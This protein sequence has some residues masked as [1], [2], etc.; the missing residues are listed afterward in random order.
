MTTTL[1][2]AQLAE[3]RAELERELGRLR[4]TLVSTE[5]AS[6]PV[7]VDQSTDG[8]LSPTDA[9]ANQEMA[10][11]LHE[12]EQVLETRI[13]DA[14]QRLDDG[15]YGVCDSCGEDIPYGRLLVMPEARTC[16]TCGGS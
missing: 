3:L 11:A 5:S 14:L 15:S 8:R 13:V 10:R 16:A 12:R 4:R 1:T 6:A 9:L 7:A 2:A